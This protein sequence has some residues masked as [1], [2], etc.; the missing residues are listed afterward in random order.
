MITLKGKNLMTNL[1]FGRK[2]KKPDLFHRVDVALWNDEI[3]TSMSPAP[4]AKE[5]VNCWHIAVI[6]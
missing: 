2:K 3:S 5:K 4:K 1:E 6:T